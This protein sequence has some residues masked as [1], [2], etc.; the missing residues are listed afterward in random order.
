[1]SDYEC[2]IYDEAFNLQDDGRYDKSKFAVEC[3][4]KIGMSSTGVKVEKYA[5]V[6]G[7]VGEAAK[8]LNKLTKKQEE[9]K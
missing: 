7:Q 2:I 1:M 4:R 9:N 8:I 3:A 5:L 6:G